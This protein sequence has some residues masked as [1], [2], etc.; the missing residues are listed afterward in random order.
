MRALAANTDP[1]YLDR[2]QFSAMD[3][4]FL[5][6]IR[7]KRDLPF[8]YLTL[9]ISL[10]MIPLGV[11]LYFPLAGWLWWMVA[12]AYHIFNNFVFKGPFGLMLHCTSHRRLYRQK[13]NYLNY[14][15]PWV[16]GPFFGQSPETYFSHHLGMHHV[17]NNLEEDLSSTMH[18]QRDSVKGF[19]SY[20][21]KFLFLGVY[22]TV[23]YFDVRRS[24]KLRNKLLR[25][26]ITFFIF[27]GLLA[28]VNLPATI[29]VFIIP[30]FI[31]RLIMMVGNWAQHSF[32]DAAD[33][34][35]CFKNSITCINTLYNKK[36]WNDGYHINHHLQPS[37]HY[38]QYPI[39]FRENLKEFSEN[40]ALVFEGIHF[41]HVWLYLMTKNYKKLC[42]HLVNLNGMFASEEE[43]IQL[44]KYRTAKIP[45][46]QTSSLE[47]AMG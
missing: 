25:G 6:F 42:A 10:F 19:A 43:A 15:L 20:F 13:Y 21:L 4:F 16:V 45:L 1:I 29:A 14:Y 47:G 34:G 38:T 31:S 5:G 8:V 18:Y 46:P 35:N 33:P 27:C 9:K 2:G 12:V 7:D 24:H 36:C 11:M 37:M 23:H 41:L 39:H 26:E 22:E 17:E 44:M 40:K 28:W 32:V 30:F 3:R